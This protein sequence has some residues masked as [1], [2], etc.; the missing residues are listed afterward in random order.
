MLLYTV[1][2]S[3]PLIQYLKLQPWC[4]ITSIT[5]QYH[6]EL[7]T[8]VPISEAGQGGGWEC[9]PEQFAATVQC[10]SVYSGTLNTLGAQAGVLELYI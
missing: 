5:S 3:W 1:G 4:R 8:N 2:V 7:T 9:G 10:A 6:N